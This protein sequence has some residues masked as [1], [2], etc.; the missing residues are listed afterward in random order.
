MRQF[1]AF[2]AGYNRAARM[3]EQMETDGVE[4]ALN[5]SGT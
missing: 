2:N 1:Q 5:D 3:V 4:S